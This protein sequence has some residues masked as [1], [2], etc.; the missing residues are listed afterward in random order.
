MTLKK[1]REYVKDRSEKRFLF[2]LID[3]N[4][5]QDF[6][7]SISHR[8][9]LK[10]LKGRSFYI[11]L[12][13][14]VILR[15]II[16]DPEINLFE[17]NIVFSG[18]GKGY[19][20]LPIN[21]RRRL[22]ELKEEIEKWLLEKF[23]GRLMASFGILEA[24]A[25]DFS[26]QNIGKSWQRVLELASEDRQHKFRSIIR[27][28]YEKFFEP[29]Q[30]GGYFGADG[31]GEERVI[32]G[33][34]RSETSKSK[35]EPE[36]NGEYYICEECRRFV[37][38]GR[39]LKDSKYVVFSESEFENYLDSIGEERKT[40]FGLAEKTFITKN[41]TLVLNFS[42]EHI[43]QNGF[44][45][46]VSFGFYLYGG[47]SAPE[48]ETLEDLIDRSVGIERLGILKMDV[49]NLGL[50]MSR[51]LRERTLSRI[52]Q[53]SSSISLFFRGEINNIIARS[54]YFKD[55]I[56]VIYAGGDD[57]F[58]VGSWEAIPEFASE[59]RRRFA[60]YACNNSSLT[61]SAGI[62]LIKKSY[63][64]YRGALYTTQAEDSAKAYENKGK[65]K[66]AVDF[67]GITV[68]WNDLEV[69][70][71]M[72]NAVV[73]TC[74]RTGKKSVLRQ[75]QAIDGIYKKQKR[76][77]AGKKSLSQDELVERAK[78]SRWI[79]LIAYMIGRSTEEDVKQS[80]ECIRT[81]LIS[82]EIHIKEKIVRSDKP[83]IEFL[84][85]PITWADYQIRN[86]EERNAR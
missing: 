68:S 57:L 70:R 69:S 55:S 9:G 22:E 47:R 32:C 38:I 3:V 19:L 26:K 80:L 45:K 59:V 14:E 62:H 37:K 61:I 46:N 11:E 27:Q 4:G 39:K 31:M 65:K 72:K 58:A 83:V 48:A 63:P 60:R 29:K 71:I 51:G 76:L 20:L 5:I 42:D 56:Y 23:E 35:A 36:D 50:V 34:C 12:L 82:D 33:I 44:S 52:S 41:R 84:E 43:P 67:L 8:K 49:D 17:S 74:K 15:H 30:E 10:S 40:Y 64:L 13:S 21:Y 16:W 6:I 81:A 77:V 79:W 25:D 18:G 53:L 78:W 1:I 73:E 24:S 7:Y 75:L 86:K 66:D 54:Q 28:N 2:V 85:L